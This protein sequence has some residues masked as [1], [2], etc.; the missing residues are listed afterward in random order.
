MAHWVGAQGLVK[1]VKKL[2]KHALIVTSLTE[3][4]KKKK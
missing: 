4:P 3:N 1:L 2:R